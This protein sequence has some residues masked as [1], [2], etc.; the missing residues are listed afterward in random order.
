MRARYGPARMGPPDGKLCEIRN[1]S[2]RCHP[3][4]AGVTGGVLG[5]QEDRE[6]NLWV[7]LNMGVWRLKPGPPVFYTVPGL[8]GGRMQSMVDSDDGAL[9]I[10]TTGAIM[11]LANGKAE[12]VYRYPSAKEGFPFP[13]N[14]PR[15]RRRTVGRA[16]GPRHFAYT[17]GTDR[18]VFPIGRPV[19]DD[20]YDLFEDREGNIWV[21]TINGLDRFSEPSVV[22]YSRKQGLSDIPWGGV[23]AAKDGSVWFA[24]LDGLNRLNQDNVTTYHRHRA[25]EWHPRDCRQRTAG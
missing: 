16:C 13:K 6:G 1:G 11:R 5:L 9:L 2:T 22:T 25:A 3:E 21:D 8:P 19:G 12:V 23:L 7:G 24:T 18:C 17:P 14:A 10:A 20:I 15:S 4:V